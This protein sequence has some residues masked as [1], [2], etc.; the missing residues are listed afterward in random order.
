MQR[1]PYKLFVFCV[2]CIPL[3]FI[4]CIGIM[5][6]LYDPMQVWHK[7]YWR[8]VAFFNYIGHGRSQAKAVIDFYPFDSIIMGSSMLFKSSE[9]LADRKLGGVWVNFS[10]GGADNHEK[11]IILDYALSHKKIKQVIMSIEGFWRTVDKDGENF[12]YLYDNNPLTNM[13][14]YVNYRFIACAVTW[15]AKPD[16]IGDRKEYRH[17]FIQDETLPNL[18]A[19][20][21]VEAWLLRNDT[22][23][24]KALFTNLRNFNNE[25]Y[26]VTPHHIDITRHR[27]YLRENILFLASKYPNTRFHFVIPTYTR[28]TFRLKDEVHDFY[29]W[30]IILTLLV[31]MAKEMP[32]V[33]IYGFDDLDYADNLANYFDTTHYSAEMNAM[34]IEA[35]ATNTHRITSTT[36]PV[37]L[38]ATEDKIKKYN[39]TQLAELLKSK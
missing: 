23:K 6:Y 21:G 31:E 24:N 38:Q 30:K 32:N 37:Y 11:A 9:D 22:K 3:P 16:C 15:S 8:D 33:R 29:Q 2:L 14:L 7:P 36:L 27:Q 39:L 4:V 35:I 1:N 12:S 10:T 25:P 20:D 28:L 5:L 17:H 26:V 19:L 18:S 13:K 34:Q